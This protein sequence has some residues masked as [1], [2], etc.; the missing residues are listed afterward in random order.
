MNVCVIFDANFLIENKDFEY[1]FNNKNSDE[2]Y[3]VTDI[4]INEIK[5]INDRKLKQMYDKYSQIVDSFLNERYFKLNNIIDL[6]VVF[7]DSSKKISKYFKH[8]FGDNII[9]GYS[10]EQMYDDLMC[11]VRFKKPPFF[12]QEGTSDKGFKDT[13]I[14]MSVLNFGKDADYEKYIFVTNDKGFIKRHQE[15]LV[16]EFLE[17]CPQKELDIVSSID[18][19]KEHSN[20]SD[21]L[22]DEEVPII[23]STKEP[24]KK[25]SN[26][27]IGEYREIVNSFFMCTVDGG[28]FEEDFIGNNF[29][30]DRNPDFQDIVEFLDVISDKKNQYIFHNSIDIS[31]IFSNLGYEYIE[32]EQGIDISAYN[33]LVDT[34]QNIKNVY[35]EYLE[36]FVKYVSDNFCKVKR[37]YDSRV[38]DD[39]PF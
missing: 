18:F 16:N 35:L 37:V 29:T 36:S 8:Y 39:L 3:F 25:L 19:I 13:L 14:W 6:E 1:L 21:T 26:Q 33:D 10:K 2:D 15:S 31:D 24:F 22:K 32:Q 11:R 30:L 9:F 27:A 17:G 38:E 28:P 5:A 34:Y 7:K 12:N 20:D 23:S 4:V